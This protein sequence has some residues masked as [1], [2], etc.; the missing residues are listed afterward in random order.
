MI[1]RIPGL[2]LGL[3]LILVFSAACATRVQ[4]P[5][6]T[7][8]PIPTLAPSAT[9]TPTLQPSPTPLPTKEPTHV[10]TAG[11]NQPAVLPGAFPALIR[12]AMADENNGWG[13]SQNGVFTTQDGGRHWKSVTPVSLGNSIVANG[14]FSGTL[15]ASIT[16]PGADFTTGTFFRT[17]D[18]GQTW[19]STD[20]PFSGGQI[21][22]LDAQDGWVLFANDC[23]AGSCGGNLYAT[24][25]GGD[26]WQ[27]VTTIEPTN[28]NPPGKIPF[29][30]DKSGVTFLTPQRGWVT[31]SI[32]MT[33]YSYLFMTA[34]G[35]KTWTQQKLTLPQGYTSVMLN[36]DPP[37]FFSVTDGILPVSI[38]GESFVEAFYTTKDGG[39][40]WT[41]GVPVGPAGSYDFVSM[42]DGFVWN[43]GTLHAT[44]DGGQTW[45]AI[46]PNVDLNQNLTG[47]DFVNPT[48]GWAAAM[49]GEG[50]SFLY[51]TTDGG[52]TWTQLNP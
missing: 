16:I 30:G 32:P 29:S 28:G 14:F 38:A 48:T 31:G 46:K 40:T 35:G 41:P 19:K 5:A 39:L 7:E 26:T 49:N 3:C 25:D 20:V 47:I 33:D 45:S 43:G 36:I 10:P 8:T 2:T 42:Q 17:S 34:D 50:K 21:F 6:S 27:V 52:K 37:R 15:S 24:Q 22:F 13:L 11:P 1:K 23:G 44:H 12:L 18:G 4:A 9:S 51:Q